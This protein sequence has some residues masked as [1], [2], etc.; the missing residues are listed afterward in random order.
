[1]EYSA[2]NTTSPSP[3]Q[4]PGNTAEEKEERQYNLENSAS[5]MMWP[6]QSRAHTAATI[7]HKALNPGMS[8]AKRMVTAGMRSG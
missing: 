2:L 4:G 6:W 5:N 7:L 8:L 1:M 3:V